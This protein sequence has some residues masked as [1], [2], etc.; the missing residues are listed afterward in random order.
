MSGPD[1]RPGR[2][3]TVDAH[4]TTPAEVRHWV[5]VAA[6]AAADKQ[7]RDV[8]ALEIGKVS[9]LCD[10]FLICDSANVRQL[11]TLV[12]EIE[13]R[14]SETG[15]PRPLAVEGLET[16]VWVLL[17]YGDLVVHVFLDEAREHYGLERLWGDVPRLELE[18][19]LGTAERA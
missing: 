18:D 12:E 19:L 9:S 10:W 5:E 14:V 15:G 17:D 7:G 6:Q 13:R 8:V 1:E 3:P 11:K 4:D 2:V 16:C